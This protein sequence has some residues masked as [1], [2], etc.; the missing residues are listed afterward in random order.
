MSNTVGSFVPFSERRIAV[1]LI[2][3]SYSIDRNTDQNRQFSVDA[4][5]LITVTGKLDREKMSVH[6]VH[7][8]AVDKGT[9][10]NKIIKKK[11]LKLNSLK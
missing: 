11:L 6:R 2:L 4:N 3:Y 10:N 5:G 1:P 7:I 8:L 9:K